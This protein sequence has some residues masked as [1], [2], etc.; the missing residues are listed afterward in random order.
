MVLLE[1]SP[2]FLGGLLSAAAGIVV[3]VFAALIGGGPSPAGAVAPSAYTASLDLRDAPLTAGSFAGFGRSDAIARIV[4]AGAPERLARRTV[5]VTPATPPRLI[6]IFD[7]VG[8]DAKAF[9]A[10]MAMPGPVTLSFLP[11]AKN[12]QPLVDR[13][14]ARGDDVMLH[15]PMEAAGAADPGPFALT[16][17][18]TGDRLFS[19]LIAN[20]DRFEGYVGVNNHMG[21]RFTRDEAAM[22]RVLAVLDRRDLFF[23]DSLTTDSSAAKRAGEAVGADVFVRDV[24]LDAES[25]KETVRRQLALAERIAIDTGYAIAICHPRRDTLEVIGPWL[26]SATARGFRLDVVSSLKPWPTALAENLPP[27]PALR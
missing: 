22:K 13:A 15:L 10:I 27:K 23:V 7:D 11:Y 5:P 16:T 14:R 19:T 8:L 12:V 2:V 18:M 6:I 1:R 26:T 3:G 4:S 20:L 9:E 21:S 24:F 17:A 25:G